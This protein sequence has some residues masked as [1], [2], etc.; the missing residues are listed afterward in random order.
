MTPEQKAHTHID[1]L[2]EQAGW[3]VQDAYSVNLSAGRGVAIREFGLKP[4][5]GTADYPL[6][7]DG[8]AA[9]VIEAKP[10][11]HTLTGVETQSGKYS[12][13]LPDALPAHRKPLP[14]LYETTGS[15][16]RFTNLIDPEPRSRGVF[17][18]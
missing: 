14:F 17:V 10:A 2:L 3:V 11:G 18:S 15:E 5:H 1:S 13:G 8:K 12:D 7:V 4:G 6:Y 16:T 9:G